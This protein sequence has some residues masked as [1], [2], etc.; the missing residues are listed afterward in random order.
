[1]IV[2]DAFANNLIPR[3]RF[4]QMAS[5]VLPFGQGV[6]PNRGGAIGTIDYVRNNWITTTGTLVRPQDKFSVKLDHLL[7]Q[8]HRLAYFFNITRFRLKPGPGGPPGL[9]APLWTGQ[10]QN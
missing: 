4:S 5:G 9:P 7:T 10:V 1:T 3:S 2:R 8:N 6:T